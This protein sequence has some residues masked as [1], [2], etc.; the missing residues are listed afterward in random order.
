MYR[1]NR[2]RESEAREQPIMRVERQ[3]AVRCIYATAAVGRNR[4]LVGL[5]AVFPSPGL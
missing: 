1:D 4:P 2:D 3:G 5:T